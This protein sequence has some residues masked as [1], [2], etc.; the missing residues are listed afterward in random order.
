MDSE[1][2][3]GE[4]K[5]A[6]PVWEYAACLLHGLVRVQRQEGGPPLS[7]KML[8]AQAGAAVEGIASIVQG[9]GCQAWTC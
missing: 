3:A 2:G 5:Q 8:G 1:F 7:E 6:S 4:E 9:S